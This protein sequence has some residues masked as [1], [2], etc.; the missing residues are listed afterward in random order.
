MAVDLRMALVELLRT[1]EKDQDADFLRDGV[2]ALMPSLMDIEVSQ[3][4]H[5]EPQQRTLERT[6]QRNG[7]RQRQWDTRVGSRACS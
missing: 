3:H 5:A 4:R 7:Y 6:G 2:R 1:A